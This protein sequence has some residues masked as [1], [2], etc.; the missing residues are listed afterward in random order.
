M[1]G[2]VEELN[3]NPGVALGLVFNGNAQ[4]G[5]L[6]RAFSENALFIK[7]SKFHINNFRVFCRELAVFQG[8]FLCILDI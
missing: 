8:K 3:E 2:A 7:V 1:I 4:Y 6:G 5:T